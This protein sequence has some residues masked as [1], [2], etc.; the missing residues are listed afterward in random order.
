MPVSTSSQCPAGRRRTVQHP[1]PFLRAH[2]LSNPHEIPRS[3]QALCL[4]FGYTFASE[5][6]CGT[7]E[8]DVYKSAF[9]PQGIFTP[10]PACS[11]QV[12]QQHMLSEPR[13]YSPLGVFEYS[14][15]GCQTH[16]S[17]L[18]DV[19]DVPSRLRCGFSTFS[20][21][22]LSRSPRGHTE[23]GALVGRG[24]G[25]PLPPAGSQIQ[26][27]RTKEYTKM[28]DPLSFRHERQRALAQ[29]LFA[30]HPQQ[31]LTPLHQRLGP[32]AQSLC[33]VRGTEGC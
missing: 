11:W 31:M 5:Q 6:R 14:R 22:L 21:L 15:T 24:A 20:S 8:M 12:Y 32:G 25:V 16:L 27:R 29:H 13:A 4:H 19:Q 7:H 17:I 18:S 23:T 9:E 26:P 28:P 33:W 1:S 30:P 3:F 10:I 2:L